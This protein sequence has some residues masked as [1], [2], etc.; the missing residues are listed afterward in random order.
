MALCY[1]GHIIN[2]GRG[3]LTWFWH[4]FTGGITKFHVY[5]MG[6][7]VIKLT[8]IGSLK[9]DFDKAWCQIFSATPLFLFW[10]L[11]FERASGL[12]DCCPSPFYTVSITYVIGIHPSLNQSRASLHN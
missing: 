7:G 2:Y 1:K 10:S 12:K 4:P 3:G 8:F 9:I 5:K 11:I 6:G